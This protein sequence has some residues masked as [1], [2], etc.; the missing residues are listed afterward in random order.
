[1]KYHILYTIDDVILN[2]IWKQ[3]QTFA[4]I[5]PNHLAFILN[6]PH[7]QQDEKP[8]YHIISETFGN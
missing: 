4:Y 5:L 1:M 6:F 2:L 3:N 8:I 7:L